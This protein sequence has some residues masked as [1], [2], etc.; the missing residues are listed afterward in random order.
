M[1]FVFFPILPLVLCEL[2]RKIKTEI[3]ILKNIHSLDYLSVYLIRM[4][5][6]IV[7]NLVL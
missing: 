3:H 4:N 6:P 2:H 7:Y 5:C 1:I